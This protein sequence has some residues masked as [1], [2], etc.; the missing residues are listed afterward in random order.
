MSEAEEELTTRA[1]EADGAG[2]EAVGWWE[3]KGPFEFM[4][5]D[6]NLT[7]RE[8]LETLEA[9]RGLIERLSRDA[10]KDH[11]AAELVARTRLRCGV[12]SCVLG[13][14]D[15]ATA[16][17]EAVR[18]EKGAHPALVQAA[19]WM[20]S[21]VYGALGQYEQAIACWSAVLA[22]YEGA[23]TKKSGALPGSVTMLYL[24]RAQA[25]AEQGKFAEAVDDCDRAERYHPECAEVFSVRGLCRANLGDMDRALADCDRSV[26]LE[27]GTARC[28]R[29]RGVVRRM[30]REFMP[31]I[32]DF[33]QALEL[34][35]TDEH[36][37]TGRSEALL[38]YV[39]LDLLAPTPAPETTQAVE[40]DSPGAGTGKGVSTSSVEAVN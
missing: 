4:G 16:F 7:R 22:E 37:R 32:S 9:W 11:R 35:P 25:C 17:L 18:D 40:R 6:M 34:D 12:A 39:L 2:V 1:A 33:D 29:R 24:F 38:G 36:A 28:Y 23:G 31:A 8:L 13:D 15:A 21:S 5:F 19:T 14:W 26:E 10:E 20:L 30:R 27:P 3:G